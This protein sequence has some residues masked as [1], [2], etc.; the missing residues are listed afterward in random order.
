MAFS[1]SLAIQTYHDPIPPQPLFVQ[2]RR[3]ELISLFRSLDSFGYKAVGIHP[4]MTHA[5]KGKGDFRLDRS[6]LIGRSPLSA[7][8]HDGRSQLW[9]SLGLERSHSIERAINP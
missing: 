2:Q 1:L 9:L 7:S 3:N 6:V 5:L 8:A 4:K